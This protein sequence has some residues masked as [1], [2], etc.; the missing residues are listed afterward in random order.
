MII[1]IPSKNINGFQTL[2]AEIE[3][4]EIEK[5]LFV[6][7]TSAYD[8][9]NQPIDETMG[10]ESENKPLSQIEA[11]FRSSTKFDTTIVRFAGLI[12]YS[13]HPGRFF[14]SGKVI[15]DPENYVNLIHRDDC[16]AIINQLIE[17]NIWGE[18]FNCCAN[19]HPTKREYYSAAAKA[20]GMDIPQFASPGSSTYKIISNEKIKQNLN[21]HFLHADLL[22]MNYL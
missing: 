10:C 1:N 3:K 19:T 20:I 14:S 8:N 4:S 16:I 12:G 13:R 17:E 18:V 21:Y 5:V 11:L 6:S 2:I 22:D 7:S 9:L 15:K